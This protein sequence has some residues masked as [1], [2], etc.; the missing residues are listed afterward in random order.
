M[1]KDQDRID[2]LV[3]EQHRG[4]RHKLLL[5]W[6]HTPQRTDVVDKACLSQWYPSP[7]VVDGLRFATAEHWMMHGKAMLFGDHDIAAQVLTSK[8]PA[9]AKKLGRMVRGFGE[10]AW[11]DHRFELIVRGTVHK[12]QQHNALREWLLGTKDKVLVEA[13]PMD[14]IWGIGLA[15]DSDEAQD[16]ARWRG[17]NLL[18]FALMAARAQLAV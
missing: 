5:F 8:S 17:L 1:D 2:A 18:G 13:S 7:F 14:R 11:C 6:G 3:A 9:A 12:F 16:P 10:V 4:K 15:A